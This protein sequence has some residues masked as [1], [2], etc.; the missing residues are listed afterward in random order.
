MCGRYTMRA[1]AAKIAEHFE[2]DPLPLL[3]PRFNI[4]PTQQ[5]AAVRL[6]HAQPGRELVRLR[7]GLVPSWADDLKI[8]YKLINAR[9]ESAA[10]KPAFRSAFKQRRCLIAAD[11][12]YEWQKLDAKHKQPFFIHL[13]S[14]DPFAF[15]GLWEHWTAA[16]GEIVESCSILTTEANEVMQPLHDRMPVILPPAE[17]EA[18]LNPAAKPPALQELLR[19]YSKNDLTA[20]PVSTLVNNA[21]NENPRC[22]EELN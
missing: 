15:A 4:A 1:P 2:V 21:R 16:D 17:Y 11:G 8:G 9:A 14:D 22:V 13:K 3:E 6:K 20:H 18:W 12:F 5:V 10:T 7:W 19:P